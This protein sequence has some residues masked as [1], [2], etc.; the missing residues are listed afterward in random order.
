[1][2]KACLVLMHTLSLRHVLPQTELGATRSARLER[3][4]S[5]RGLPSL[6]EHT[7]V[8]LFCSDCNTE[9]SLYFDNTSHVK[10][11]VHGMEFDL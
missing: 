9:W 6:H 7:S 2:H 1:M 4:L 10:L 11:T 5:A 8:I 3:A